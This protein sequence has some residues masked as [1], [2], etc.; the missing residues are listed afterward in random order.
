[1]IEFLEHI[2]QQI[3]LFLNG[4]HNA[5]FDQVVW[6]YSNKYSWFPFYAALIFVLIKKDKWKGLYAVLALIILITLTDQLSVH[7]FK[8]V[9]QRYRPCH[10]LDLAGLV[11]IVKNKCGGT[12]GFVSSHASNSFGLAIFTLLY[13]RNRTFSW[14]VL[15]W[16]IL[17]AYS[18]I[19][20][21]VH[22]PADVVVGGLFGGVL[23][24]GI[25]KGY[26]K[27]LSKLK[28]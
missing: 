15:V 12:Y 5:F 22:Y 19:Y 20:L 26:Q 10:N 6:L 9:F 16:A 11:H 23:G 25:L 1:M 21:G 4:F 8:N 24:Y 3:F 17:I 7:L 27:V 28:I 13:F 18:R 14:I 2:D